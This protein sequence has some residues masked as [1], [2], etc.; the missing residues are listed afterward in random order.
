MA[1]NLD[2]LLPKDWE[3]DKDILAIRCDLE[4]A[5]IYRLIQSLDEYYYVLLLPATDA[6]IRMCGLVRRLHCDVPIVLVGESKDREILLYSAQLGC[7][8]FISYEDNMALVK[9]R[10]GVYVRIYA[11]SQKIKRAEN[12]R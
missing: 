4:S 2:G 5:E 9:K 1:G 7:L 12:R 11:M 3:S 8:D 10:L 6:G